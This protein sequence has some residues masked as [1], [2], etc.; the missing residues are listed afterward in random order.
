MQTHFKNMIEK[1]TEFENSENIQKSGKIRKNPEKS[2]KNR[3][4]PEKS[5]K[6]RS[7]NQEK[8]LE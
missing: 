3:K 8:C 4:N 7:E 2:G 1:I 6:I 5:R